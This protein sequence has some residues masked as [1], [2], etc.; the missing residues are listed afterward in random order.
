MQIFATDGT[1]D[2]LV[3]VSSRILDVTKLLGDKT[4][5]VEKFIHGQKYFLLRSEICILNSVVVTPIL[6]L[7]SLLS[8]SKQLAGWLAGSG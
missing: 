1:H 5:I 2:F 7:L 6:S 3:D 4:V 8:A